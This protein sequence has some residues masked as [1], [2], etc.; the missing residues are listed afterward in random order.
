M[1]NTVKEDNKDERNSRSCANS[2]TSGINNQEEF[3]EQ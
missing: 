1:E 2:L 3:E